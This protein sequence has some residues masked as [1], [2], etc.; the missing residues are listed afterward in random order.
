[1]SLPL[2]FSSDLPEGLEILKQIGV[3]PQK[4][5]RPRAFKKPLTK[6]LPSEYARRCAHEQAMEVLDPRQWNILAVETVVCCGRRILLPTEDLALAK[7]YLGLLSGRRHRVYG[8]VVLRTPERVYR[9][10]AVTRIAWKSLS[11]EEIS[12]YL[13]TDEWRW[14]PGGYRAQG[15]ADMFVRWMS[16]SYSNLI[17][18]PLFETA[19]LL[20]S[21][22]AVGWMY[23]DRDRS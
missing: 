3:K 16:G 22:G 1:M 7:R 15:Y 23:A 17:G 8:A 19:T 12:G 14:R 18:L 2:A 4:I 10:L 21:I 5:V 13:S 9:R 20:R 11:L 6:E